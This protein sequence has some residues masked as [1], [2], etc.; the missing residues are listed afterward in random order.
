MN[1]LKNIAGW[2]VLL[3]VFRCLSTGLVAEAP[4]QDAAQKAAQ[5]AAGTRAG[6]K[7]SERLGQLIR[8]RLPIDGDETEDVKQYANRIVSKARREKKRPV[9][10]FEFFDPNDEDPKRAA[11]S[12]FGAAYDLADFI[13]GSRLGDAVTVAYIPKAVR[14]QAVLAVMACDQIIMAPDAELG[15]VGPEGTQ[16]DA[17][18]RS[19]YKT[20][21]S[22]RRTI[23]ESVAFGLLDPAEEVWVVETEVSREFRNTKELEE[24]EKEKTVKGKQILFA[25][26]RPGVLIGKEARRLGFVGYLA[27]SPKDLAK[28]LKV[29]ENSLLLD[30]S[31]GR[32]W[33][34]AQVRVEGP[35]DAAKVDQCRRMIEEAVNKNDSNFLCIWINSPGGSPVDSMRLASMI[36]ELPAEKVRTTAFIAEEAR[37]DAALIALACDEIFIKPDAVLGGSGAY[38]AD[39]REI[40][41]TVESIRGSL[42][43]EKSRDWSL[44]AAMIDPEL[45]VFECTRLDEVRYWSNAELAEAEN[46]DDWT[47]GR[48]VTVPGQPFQSRGDKAVDYGLADEVVGSFAEYKAHFNLENDPRLLEPSWADSLIQALSSPG[49]A[50]LLL[51]IGGVGLY[52]ELQAPGIGVGGFVFLVCLVLFFWSNYL[53]GTAGWLEALLFVAGLTCVLLEIFVLPGFGIFGLGGGALILFSLVLA[54]QTFIIPQN[55]YQY[56]QFERSLMTLGGATIGVFLGVYLLNK[57][58]P[59]TPYFNKMILAPPDEEEA[60]VLRKRESLVD[61]SDLLGQE[62]TTTTK[63]VPSGKAQIG[64]R[65]VDVIAAESQIIPMGI[66]VIV[67]AVHGARVL[68]KPLNEEA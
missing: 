28:A 16:I 52:A 39:R 7:A 1:E 21:A 61:F 6:S 60:V 26:G 57:Y 17:P 67:T 38:Q 23:P 27:D 14:G 43:P 19:A 47:K 42:A 62:G 49:V 68:V 58:L 24:L 48:G 20:I 36:A 2:V 5:K 4:A 56:A 29:P 50:M 10:V 51:M 64:D 11:A 65:Y 13:S 34:T 18:I 45:E 35:V 12:Q 46:P 31:M 44:P 54:G 37:S 15:P 66:P 25:E 8:V 33:R 53:G 59:H 32:E 40:D 55:P 30:P 41:A 9:L 3:A 22:R 63:L